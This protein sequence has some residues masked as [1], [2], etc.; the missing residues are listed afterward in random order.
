M[1]DVVGPRHGLHR[2]PREQEAM[3]GETGARST[4]GGRWAEGAN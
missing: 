2:G 4:G 3:R 1:A